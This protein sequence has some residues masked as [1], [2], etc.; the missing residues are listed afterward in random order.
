MYYKQA[1]LNPYLIYGLYFSN[2]QLIQSSSRIIGRFI[3]EASFGLFL[4]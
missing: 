3:E 1:N 2:E 4:S